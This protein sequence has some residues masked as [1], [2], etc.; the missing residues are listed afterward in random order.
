[1]YLPINK[2]EMLERGITQPDFVYITGDAYVDHP[3]FGTAIISRVLESEGFSVCII[4]QPDWRN[5]KSIDVFGEPKL[6]F[7]VS[8]GNMDSMVNHYSV[9][10]KRRKK[11]FYSPNAEMGKRPDYATIVYG[12]LIRQTYKKTPIIIGGIEASLRRLSHYDYW[13]D[14][15]K[16]SVLLDSNADLLIYGMG[17]K[18]IAEVAHSLKNGIEIKDINFVKGTVFKT[19]IPEFIPDATKLPGFDKITTSK[20]MYAKSFYK[21][22]Q[23]TDPFTAKTLVES[24][25]RELFVIQNSPQPPLTMSEMDAVYA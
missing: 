5:P 6:G 8:A 21:Q 4:P 9:S 3:S 15:V 16:R 23:N 11:D 12:N 18:A 20:E 24:Y 13:S 10:K 22:Y 1:M 25:G 19:N 2:K 14:T 7:L 17:E